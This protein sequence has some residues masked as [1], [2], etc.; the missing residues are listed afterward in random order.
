LPRQA[1]QII[2]IGLDLVPLEIVADGRKVDA[3]CAMS[4]AH[5]GDEARGRRLSS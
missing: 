2:A 3:A 1:G 4:D 5:L